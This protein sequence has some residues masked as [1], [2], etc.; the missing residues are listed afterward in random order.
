M[1]TSPVVD[2]LGCHSEI[3]QPQRD[4]QCCFPPSTD[5]PKVRSRAMDW[6]LR[7]TPARDFVAPAVVRRREDEENY[8]TP[9]VWAV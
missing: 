8:S 2:F 9:V 7:R 1:R 4:I 6:R 3:P 5:S